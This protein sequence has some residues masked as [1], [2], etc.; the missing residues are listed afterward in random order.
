M[1]QAHHGGFIGGEMGLIDRALDAL[2]G[3][4]ASLQEWD[5]L[6]PRGTKRAERILTEGEQAT[7]RIAGIDRRLEDS[8]TAVFLAL[9]R[10]GLGEPAVSGMRLGTARFRHRLRLGLELPVRAE[11]GDG[12]AALLDWPALWRRWGVQD[13]G[14][15]G[16]LV[17]R[18]IPDAGV[19]DRAVDAREQRALKA[20][21]RIRVRV[22]RLSRRS[23]L[24][25]P[26]M[27]W[28]IALEDEAGAQLESGGFEVPFY[29]SW[30]AAEGAELPAA[31]DPRH[32]GRAVI[33]W[34]AA[35]TEA[36]ARPGSVDDPP[37]P[38]S[39]AEALDRAVAQAAAAPPAFGAGAPA[40]PDLPAPDGG[41]APIEGVSLE[42]WAQ[43]EIGTGVD[44]VKP[45]DYDA[46]AASQGVPPGRWQAISAAWNARTTSDWRVGAAVGEALEA[47]RK[48]RKRRR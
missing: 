28:D 44:R 19:R 40:P 6:S 32:A 16:Q 3:R 42:L 13:D 31:I 8:T 35:A 29:A 12:G 48:R 34:A 41:L 27:N 1:T 23:A 18:L 4:G 45:A 25:A 33:D 47:E 7:G 10:R 36:A 39:V 5:H 24:G 21:E 17:A 43:V 46:Y 15:G 2:N 38:A 9:E 30:I 14:G 20:P 11:A 37:P 26:S 22:V